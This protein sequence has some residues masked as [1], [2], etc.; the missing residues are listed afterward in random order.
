MLKRLT[1]TSKLRRLKS[2]IEALYASDSRYPSLLDDT[3]GVLERL[4]GSQQ[5]AGAQAELDVI[6]QRLE[7]Q[8]PETN[9]SRRAVVC[10][11]RHPEMEQTIQATLFMLSGAAGFVLLPA[12]FLRLL[13]VILP[14]LIFLAPVELLLAP[15]SSALPAAESI[16]AAP[17]AGSV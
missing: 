4:P 13:F 6:A 11:P 9:T 16:G 10:S 15:F 3:I 2:E 7:K 17:P 14:L 8:Y 5:L 12:L 1:N